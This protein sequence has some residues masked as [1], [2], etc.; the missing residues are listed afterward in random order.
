M[1]G[2]YLDLAVRM[3]EKL[4]GF[5]VGASDEDIHG[6]EKIFHLV[7]FAGGEENGKHSGGVEAE[8]LFG[9]GH[10]EGKFVRKDS[11]LFYLSTWK[12]GFGM[13]TDDV[14]KFLPVLL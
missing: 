1:G 3:A 6:T 5:V 7:G 13:D 8:D 11:L 4:D 12:Y 2:G 14:L 10:A 9:N